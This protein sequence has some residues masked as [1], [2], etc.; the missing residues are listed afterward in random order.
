[1]IDRQLI[2]GLLSREPWDR[3]VASAGLS[4]ELDDDG[5]ALVEFDQ[6]GVH[7]NRFTPELLERLGAVLDELKLRCAEGTVRGVMFTSAKENSFIVGVDIAAIESV[8][9]EAAAIAATRRGQEIFQ[10]IADLPVITVA[11]INGTCLGG[12]TEMALACTFRVVADNSS[13]DIGFPEVNL[14]FF[15]GFGGSQRLPRMI[16]LER[17]LPMILGGKAVTAARARKIGLVDAV[18]PAELLLTEARR[19]VLSPPR[20]HRRL[21]LEDRSWGRFFRRWLLEGQLVGRMIMFHQAG[22]SVLSRVGEHYPAPL[23]ALDTVRRGLKMTLAKGLKLEAEQVGRLI[24]SPTSRN[25]VEIF[26]SR[27]AARRTAH[28]RGNS[29]QGD[30]TRKVN[31][32]GVVGAGVMGG[33][34]AQVAAY[35]QIPV[36][37][38]DVVAESLTTGYKVA[39]Q[40]FH[41]RQRAG[42]LSSREVSQRMGLIS[43]TLAYTGF[44]TADLVIESVVENLDV[45]RSVLSDI[46]NVTR[47]DTVIA[48][49]TSSLTLSEMA[50]SMKRPGRFVGLHFFNPVHRM[51]LVEVVCSELA[52]ADA[53]GCALSFVHRLGK[54]PVKVA[55]SPGFLVNRVL[56]PYLNEALLL[57][58]SGVPTAQ[59]DGALKHFGMPMGPLRL[60]DEIG[61]DVTHH[62]AGRLGPV[63]GERVLASDVGSLMCK[64]GRLGKKVLNGFYR[65]GKRK[66]QPVD[67]GEILGGGPMSARRPGDEEITDRCV[68]LMFNEACYALQENIVESAGSLD[69]AMVMGTGFP[70]FRGGILRYADAVGV[71]CLRDRLQEL[72][73]LL[74]G[75]FEPAPLLKEVADTGRFYAS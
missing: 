14:G 19:F 40:R 5:I 32:L 68:L 61:L 64:S 38:K 49:N 23:E 58:E 74:G 57:V 9:N 52:E 13:V 17:A 34:I 47:P 6:P 66:P 35:H 27:Q 75:R 2:T 42:K 62:V 72:S 65:Y 45:K 71:A 16:S 18:V 37:L 25:L 36:R 41:E 60:L 69:L 53:V 26:L 54:V 7:H 1:M 4:V 22:K 33:G 48:T 63:F 70:P 55:D 31:K 15:P 30:A 28:V 20:Y 43:P 39:Y 3:A 67:L 44:G 50:T 21:A 8:P 46:E 12:A 59:I 10:K 73:D 29:G 51:P 11:A 24:V 56:M